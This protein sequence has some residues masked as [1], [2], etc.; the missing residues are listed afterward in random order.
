MLIAVH[1]KLLALS[2]RRL[3][4]FSWHQEA[5]FTEQVSL[6]SLELMPVGQP[7]NDENGSPE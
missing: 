4:A 1:L 6:A 5:G 7:L 3:G 2:S